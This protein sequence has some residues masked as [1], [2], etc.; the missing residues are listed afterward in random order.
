MPSQ[1]YFIKGWRF[2]RL[3]KIIIN[4]AKSL[5]HSMKSRAIKELRPHQINH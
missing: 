1:Q 5:N 3:K 2:G 4:V